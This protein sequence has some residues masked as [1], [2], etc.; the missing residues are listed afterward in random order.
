V[1][2]IPLTIAA[3]VLAAAT[4]PQRVEPLVVRVDD[5]GFNWADASLGAAAG[6]GAGVALVG[7]LALSRKEKT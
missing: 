6:F 3:L 5:G 1:G 7:G 4:P 2:P